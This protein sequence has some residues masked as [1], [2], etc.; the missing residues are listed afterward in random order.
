MSDSTSDSSTFCARMKSPV[1]VFA[2][3]NLRHA[4]PVDY[5]NQDAFHYFLLDEGNRAIWQGPYPEKFSVDTLPLL[6]SSSALLKGVNGSQE[7][8]N[9]IDIEEMKSMIQG[10]ELRIGLHNWSGFLFMKCTSFVFACLLLIA[11][12]RK[13]YSGCLAWFSYSA[14][15]FI[16]SVLQ[17]LLDMVLGDFC[18]R[19][20]QFQ[21]LQGL[22][23]AFQLIGLVIVAIYMYKLCQWS[24]V[25]MKKV[26]NGSLPFRTENDVSI[27]EIINERY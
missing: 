14:P 11:T 10:A 8:D 27:R 17:F 16:R 1:F 19:R 7:V 12:N 26:S 15:V 2:A 25:G 4:H 20:L 13:N 6:L 3:V 9:D 5:R 22:D 18:Q 21:I 24:F 23:N